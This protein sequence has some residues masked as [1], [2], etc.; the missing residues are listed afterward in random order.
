MT[1]PSSPMPDDV[2]IP[3]AGLSSRQ[4]EPDPPPEPRHKPKGSSVIPIVAALVGAVLFGLLIR[5]SIRADEANTALWLRAQAISAECRRLEI[6]RAALA[7]EA[8]ALDQDPFYIEKRIRQDWRQIKE[9]EIVLERPT[10]R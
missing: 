5:S 3:P 10:R 6:Y 4:T 7:R 1:A 8:Y 2:S 9:G